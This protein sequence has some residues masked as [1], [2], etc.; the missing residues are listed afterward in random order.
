[1]IQTAI[2]GCG[3]IHTMHTGAIADLPDVQIAAV[4]D[5]KAD[6][7]Q[8][9]A[10]ELGCRWYTD[11]TKM[12]DEEQLD[13]V[14]ICT[15]HWLHGEMALEALR[16][17]IRVLVEKPMAVTVEQARAMIAEDERQGSGK[18]CVIFQNRYNAASRMLK[19]VVGGGEYGALQCLRG[20]VTWI[21]GEAY[22]SD[23]W[24]GKKALECGG[25]MI[26]QAIHTLDLVQWIGGGARTVT[27]AVSTDALKGTIEV[28]D[29][30][31]LRMELKS[32]ASAVF[33]ATVAHAVDSPVEIDAVLE[34]GHFLLRGERLFY[35]DE[36]FTALCEPGGSPVGLRDYWGTG[37]KV[38]IADFYACIREGR[39]FAIDGTQGIEAV[40]LVC[41]LYESSATGKTVVL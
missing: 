5:T 25:V 9:T 26:N 37:H 17:G 41:G 4:C 24:H 7:A 36:G 8:R 31:H 11:Y 18:L 10:E 40:K 38:Q 30:A 21:R 13:A 28:E 3:A 16:R 34:R 12:L 19:E 29:S 15:P 22:Y 32:G 33:Y 14:H 20:I 1:M 23:D 39:P 27:G 6:R 2:I 35:V